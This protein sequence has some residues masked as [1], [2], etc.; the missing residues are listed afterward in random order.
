MTIL[1]LVAGA[2]LALAS[3]LLGPIDHL[4]GKHVGDG[5]PITWKIE[6]FDE[7]GRTFVDAT[8][9]H[10]YHDRC[11]GGFRTDDPGWVY[12]S[13]IWGQYP[14][15]Y[16][17]TT[18]RY[19]ITLTNNSPRSYVNIRVVAIQ[20]Y[21]TN[22]GTW[23]E[24]ISPE[25][26]KDWYVRELRGY[27]TMVFEGSLYIPW[28]AHGGLDQ[29]HLQVQHWDKGAGKPGAGSVI[30]DDAQAAIWCPPELSALKDSA[31]GGTG[32]SPQGAVPGTTGSASIAVGGRGSV[33]PGR[34]PVT[35]TVIPSG[36]GNIRVLI[37][38]QKGAVVLDAVRVATSAS[39]VTV[40]WDGLASGGAPAAPG[41]YLV[42]VEGP[43][44]RTSR[45]IAVR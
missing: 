24:W 7:W 41:V 9:G 39:P 28:G 2:S 14:M 29:T 33:E 15:Y 17:G 25:A 35:V 6:Y 43:G 8:G 26:A 23:G 20:E 1:A 45:K 38:G 10:F 36:P 27:Q 12:P 11:C 4:Q 18:M 37:V 13:S 32:A 44:V 40:T 31:N 21:L 19:R 42:T 34:V 30:I 5:E 3:D 16:I 22:D